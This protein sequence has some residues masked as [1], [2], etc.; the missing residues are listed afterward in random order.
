MIIFCEV[1]EFI[2]KY[3]HCII[4]LSVDDRQYTSF[5]R[6]FEEILTRQNIKLV[7]EHNLKKHSI[8]YRLSLI[9]DNKLNIIRL[10]K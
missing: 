1:I 9:I 7:K 8:E 2:K 10:S 3:K 5:F 4:F 6:L